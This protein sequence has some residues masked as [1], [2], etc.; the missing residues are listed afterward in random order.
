M[1][2]DIHF[3]TEVKINNKWE[4]YNSPNVSRNYPLFALLANV[5]NNGSITPISNPRGLPDDVSFLTK[6]ISDK[7]GND[8]HSHSYVTSE[9]INLVEEFVKKQIQEGW[10]GEYGK[11]KV[12]WP[13]DIWGYFLG[14]GWAD[15]NNY[16]DERPDNVQDVRFVFWF[17]N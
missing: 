16:S 8:G 5:R 13:E 9:E 3:H 2:C 10:F 11:R 6:F 12:D 17:D 15:F 1:G 7:D 14:N 4:H